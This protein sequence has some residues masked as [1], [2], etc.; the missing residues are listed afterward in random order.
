MCPL[1]Q[2]LVLGV[3]RKIAFVIDG[4]LERDVDMSDFV[5]VDSGRKRRQLD[6]IR[7]VSHDFWRGY[8]RWRGV[9]RGWICRP[10]K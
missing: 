2:N 1:N 7:H 10:K 4:I 9:A 3:E 6:P 5:V 8:R